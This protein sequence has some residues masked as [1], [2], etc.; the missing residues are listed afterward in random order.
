MTLTTTTFS[1]SDK[2]NSTN[3]VSWRRLIHTTAV[4]KEAFG[5]LDGSI[6]QLSA[7]PADGAPLT[8]TSWDLETPYSKEWRAYGAWTL[9]LL[10][11]NTKNPTGSEINIDGTAA[12]AWTL[13]INT[14]E[15]AS[16]MV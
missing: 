13:Y 12:E 16:N 3:W 15:K 11:I 9:G 4:S 8:E 6:K 1:E 2:F 5:Y 7:L 10:L 14:Y